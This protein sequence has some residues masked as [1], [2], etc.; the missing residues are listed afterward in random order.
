MSIKLDHRHRLIVQKVFGHPINH[1]I[2]WHDVCTVLALF[3]DV[4]ETHRG[5]W[6]V[7]VGENTV[8]FGSARSRDLTEDQ[9]IKVRAFLRSVG[10]TPDAVTAA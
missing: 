3:G 7:S 5:N 8:S 4:H 10:V 1:N 2:Q 9:V 6:A